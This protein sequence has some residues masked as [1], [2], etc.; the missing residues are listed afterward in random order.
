MEVVV[1]DV[2]VEKEVLVVMPAGG[3]NHDVRATPTAFIEIVGS[4]VT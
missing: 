1:D 4:L 2:D 3:A